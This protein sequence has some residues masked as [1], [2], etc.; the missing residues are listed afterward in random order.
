[1][2]RSRAWTCR[3]CKRAFLEEELLALHMGRE[4]EDAL[5]EEE[6]AAYRQAWEAE[7]AVLAGLQRHVKGGLTALPI[8]MLYGFVV[9]VALLGQAN[10][11]LTMLPLPGVILISAFVYY[12]GYTSQ[13]RSEA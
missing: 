6:Q 1:M 13:P 11:A 2:N 12:L 5:T 8:L 10:P 4:H 9:M 3:V 7:E